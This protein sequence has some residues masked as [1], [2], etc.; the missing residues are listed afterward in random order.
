MTEEKPRIVYSVFVH[1][2]R[3]KELCGLR[4]KDLHSPQRVTHFRI[5]G[6]RA[7]I[8]FVQVN[9]AAQRMIEDYL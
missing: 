9:A 1:G 3:R 8:R 2:I 4:V 7:K 6:K 5:K